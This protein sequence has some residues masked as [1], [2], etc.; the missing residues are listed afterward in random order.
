MKFLSFIVIII[1]LASSCAKSPLPKDSDAIDKS[2][3]DSIFDISS[4]IYYWEHNLPT[5]KHFGLDKIQTPEEIIFKLREY[6]PNKVDKW[7]FA[8]KKDTWE[9]LSAGISK[10][11]GMGLRYLDNNDLRIAYVFPNSPADQSELKR[12]MKILEINAIKVENIDPNTIIKILVEDDNVELKIEGNNSSRTVILK[13]TT[14]TRTSILCS[15]IFKRESSKV[16][17]V[18]IYSF[19]E[20]TSAEIDSIFDFFKKANIDKLIIDLRYNGGGLLPATED[21]ANRL[22]CENSV[23]KVFYQTEYN[24]RYKYFGFKTFLRKV[25][26]SLCLPEV[27]VIVSNNTASASEVFINSIKPYMKV[28]LIGTKTAGKLLGMHALD[29]KNYLMFPIAFKIYNAIGEHDNFQGTAP[30]IEVSDD[31]DSDWNEGEENIKIGLNIN[32]VKSF[33]KLDARPNR[34][35]NNGLL[36]AGET[37]IFGA[38]SLEM[39]QAGMQ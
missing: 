33:T 32:G 25:P 18:N 35:R 19:I 10:D 1:I 8:V 38:I 36:I 7:S 17:Y 15:K 34:R 5:K 11:F 39:P 30:D 16:G 13:K 4:K 29:F 21:L 28:N 23:N 24:D 20:T 12:G 6:S 3:Y 2:L 37:S 31:V 27:S 22:V 9:N 26:G 14:Y